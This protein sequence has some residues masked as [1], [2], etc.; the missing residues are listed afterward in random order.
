MTSVL[1]LVVLFRTKPSEAERSGAEQGKTK[2]S[3]AK[4][5]EAK[6]SKAEQRRPK[7]SEAK[8]S[9]AKRSTAKQKKSTRNKMQS[10]GNLR[11]FADHGH[12]FDAKTV[13]TLLAQVEVGNPVVLALLGYLDQI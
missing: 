4:R 5:S 7:P 10:N 6:R 8:P 12:H 11:I 3:Q 9:K 13:P 2:P 1:H